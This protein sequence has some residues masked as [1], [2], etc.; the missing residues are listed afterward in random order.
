MNVVRDELPKPHARLWRTW[1]YRPRPVKHFLPPITTASVLASRPDES[2]VAHWGEYIL[3]EDHVTALHRDG[4]I[5][6]YHRTITLPRSDSS[7]AQWDEVIRSFDNRRSR[8]TLHCANVHLP[9]GGMRK[10]V[11]QSHLLDMST[12]AIKLTFAPLRPGVAVEH[13]EQYDEFRPDEVGPG[14][15]SN[16]LLQGLSPWRRYRLALAV[17]EPFAATIR[18]HHGAPSPEESHEKGYHVF[19]WDLEN[20]PGIEADSGTPPPFDFAPWVDLSTLPNWEAVVRHYRTDIAPP[21]PTPPAIRKL[22]LELTASATNDRERAQ[23]IYKYVT[24]DMRYGRHPSELNLPKVRN[25]DK[26]LEDLRGDCKD[27]SALMVSMLRE[28]RIPSDVVVLLTA[29]NGR[30]D[31]LPG[32]RFDHAIVRAE[33]EGQVMWFD[34]AAGPVEFGKIP[35]NDQGVEGLALKETSAEMVKIPLDAPE[36][37]SVR[38]TCRGALEENGDYNYRV[39]V[40]CTG[41]RA[42]AIRFSLF[43]RNEDH[44]RRL[45]QQSV[46]E[47]RPGA[48]VHDAKLENVTDISGPLRYSFGL[49]LKGWARA[50]SDLILFR[51]PWAETITYTGP[52]AA[53]ERFHPL[54][55]TERSCLDETH[56][57]RLPPGYEGYGLPGHIER[58][59]AWVKYTCDIRVVCGVLT[60]SRQIVF[61]GGIVPTENFAAYQTIWELCTRDESIDIVLRKRESLHE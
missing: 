57:M 8:S 27:K 3:L 2:Q 56:E 16:F 54:Q 1:L 48:K 55:T 30:V 51:V 45:L 22:A 18:L 15:W 31:F 61:F 5:T 26:M 38:R 44:Q 33:V 23:A 47:E 20:V 35:I 58:S 17:A 19:R 36:A 4:T 14:V 24:L 50:V 29:Q 12:G 32:R 52:L 40:T 9:E 46:A 6:L 49:Q 41:E 11:V 7:L 53:A 34:P 59:C 60:C 39:E 13:E 28:F 42:S 37:Q 10:A 25:S 43:D 21:H